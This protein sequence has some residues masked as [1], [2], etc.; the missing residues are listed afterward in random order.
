MCWPSSWYFYIIGNTK[1]K[2]LFWVRIHNWETAVMMVSTCLLPVVTKWDKFSNDLSTFLCHSVTFFFRRVWVLILFPMSE[3]TFFNSMNCCAKMSNTDM[4]YMCVGQN[5][6]MWTSLLSI[7]SG[8]HKKLQ[9]VIK[10][11][12]GTVASSLL[13]YKAGA[14]EEQAG[15]DPAHEFNIS[16][17]SGR[18]HFSE[19]SASM[20]WCCNWMLESVI[21]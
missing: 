1:S 12:S 8:S 21:L 11:V 14:G 4:E 19:S 3:C 18:S 5:V 2:P 15:H 6:L 9:L 13:F 16:E 20:S 17:S 10:G 7:W